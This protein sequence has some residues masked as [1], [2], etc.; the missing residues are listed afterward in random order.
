MSVYHGGFKN[1]VN[2]ELNR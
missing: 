1:I 2:Y